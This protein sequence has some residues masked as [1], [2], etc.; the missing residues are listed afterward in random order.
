MIQLNVNKLTQFQKKLYPCIVKTINTLHEENIEPSYS[1][2]EKRV[3]SDLMSIHGVDTQLALINLT[4]NKVININ[5]G[6]YSINNR[7]QEVVN[8]LLQICGDD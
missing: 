8:K 2:I 4:N 5:D 3:E 1:E 6:V 7:N